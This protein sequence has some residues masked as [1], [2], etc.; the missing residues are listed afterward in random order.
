MTKT[1]LAVFVLM[2]NIFGQNEISTSLNISEMKDD[3]LIQRLSSVDETIASSASLPT[4]ATKLRRIKLLVKCNL[5][6]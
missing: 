4:M 3:E 2:A 6:L 5:S 1:V